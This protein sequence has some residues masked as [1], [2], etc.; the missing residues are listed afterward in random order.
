MATAT[1]NAISLTVVDS[2]NGGNAV[3]FTDH[4][5]YATKQKDTEARSAHP[6][7]QLDTD[8]PLIDFANFFDGES[9][10]QEDM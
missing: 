3:H 7:N 8:D 6:Y 5:F 1:S 4:Q 2:T 9:L 10:D